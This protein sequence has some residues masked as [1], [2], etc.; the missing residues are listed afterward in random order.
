MNDKIELI[1]PEVELPALDEV[2]ERSAEL[3]DDVASTTA[4]W[5]RE[6]PWVTTLTRA[7]WA[8]KAI[9]YGIIGWAAIVIATG[10]PGRTEAEYSGIVAL[11]VDDWWTRLLL[12]AVAAG[13]ALYT[14]FRVL[15]VLLI[16]S[17]DLDGWAHR[18]AFSASAVTYAAVVW[19]AVD[20]AITGTH[21]N[22]RS[23][24]ERVSSQLLQSMGGRWLVG[25]SAVAAFAVAVYFVVKGLTRSFLRQL[26]LDGLSDA[27]RHA[28]EWLGAVGWI[29]RGAVVAA[30]AM[31]LLG[32]AVQADPADA[33][34]LDRSLQEVAVSSPA[35]AVTVF[36]VGV[37][38]VLYALF[39]AASAPQRSL[40]WSARN[41]P[42]STE[43]ST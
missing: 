16:D 12:L 23:S 9:V 35:G 41:D 15:S 37:L 25:A 29:G 34:G 21:T 30:V 2:Q 36:I 14:A 6:Q 8:A 7:G 42:E 32:A 1:G 17:V 24:V 38:L 19:A 22:G 10:R 26:N 4:H 39:C 43:E 5:L 20:A 28:L 40:T 33:R 27:R 3:A 18:V 31:F 13:L 11:L